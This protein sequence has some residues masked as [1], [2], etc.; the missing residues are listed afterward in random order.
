MKRPSPSDG[1]LVKP[2]FPVNPARLSGVGNRAALRF[3]TGRH[4]RTA[5]DHHIGRAWSFVRPLRPS[6]LTPLVTRWH[7]S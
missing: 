7:R 3:L 6:N 2:D 5:G 1:L 4:I